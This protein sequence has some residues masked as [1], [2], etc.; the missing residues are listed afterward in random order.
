MNDDILD[1]QLQRLRRVVAA[2]L[3]GARSPGLPALS[4]PLAS[5]ASMQEAEQTRRPV[6]P[7]SAPA[8]F[9][10]VEARAPGADRTAGA[11]SRLVGRL[12]RLMGRP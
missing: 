9:M 7:S 10:P 12:R 8:D 1:R 2:R 11:L 4:N 3:E 6:A 5:Q